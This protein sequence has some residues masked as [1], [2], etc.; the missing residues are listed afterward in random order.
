MLI[1]G[2]VNCGLIS[3]LIWP[4]NVLKNSGV[5]LIDGL[6]SFN[7]LLLVLFS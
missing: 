4:Y 5:K 3:L 6:L 1:V 7:V 2:I